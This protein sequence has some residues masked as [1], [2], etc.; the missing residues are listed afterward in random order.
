MIKINLGIINNV[1]GYLKYEGEFESGF[2]NGKG[3]FLRRVYV[4]LIQF[5]RKIIFWK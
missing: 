5:F 1:N 2:Y 4:C 3:R